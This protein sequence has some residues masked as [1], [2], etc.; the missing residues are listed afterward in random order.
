M[1][2]HSTL[3]LSTLFLAMSVPTL[4]QDTTAVEA[5][6]VLEISGIISIDDD[7][8]EEALVELFEGNQVV[9]A[10]ET[11]KNGKFKFTLFN[12]M[13]YT[14]Q[15]NKKGYYTKRISISTKLPEGYDDF[16]KFQ[17]DI[18]LT[19]KNAEKY[20]PYLAEYPSALIAFDQ[21]KKEFSFDKDYTKSYF[22]EIRLSDK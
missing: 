22:D 1:K 7:G 18:G 20:D 13:V 5:Y 11:K 12:D 19:A 2:V 21:R 9:D 8:V 14:I 3:L 10:F 17:F 16:E 15:I 4:G 6:E